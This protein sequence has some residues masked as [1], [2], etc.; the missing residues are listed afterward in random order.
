MSATGEGASKDTVGTTDDAA[1]AAAISMEQVE[2]CEK[3]CF[4]RGQ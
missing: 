4:F 2:Y 3:S 1:A